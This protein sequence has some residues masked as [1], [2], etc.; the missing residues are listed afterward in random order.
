MDATTK[1]ATCYNPSLEPGSGRLVE[2][3]RDNTTA[4]ANR[5]AGRFVIA[6][7]HRGVAEN[8]TRVRSEDEALAH[9]AELGYTDVLRADDDA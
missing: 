8:T 7:V 6:K 4:E 5:V 1:I 3:R 2:I 9:A